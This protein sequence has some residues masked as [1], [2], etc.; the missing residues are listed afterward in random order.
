[1]FHLLQKL[2]LLGWSENRMVFVSFFLFR[3]LLL[4][5]W[6]LELERGG[7]WQERRSNERDRAGKGKAETGSRRRCLFAL[8]YLYKSISWSLFLNL[9][10]SPGGC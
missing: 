6:F 9:S 3:L 2:T 1:M 7:R 4:I 8:R 5:F 10:Y